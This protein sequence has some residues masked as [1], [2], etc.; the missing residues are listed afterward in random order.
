MRPSGFLRLPEELMRRCLHRV[1]PQNLLALAAASKGCCESASDPQLWRKVFIDQWRFKK[2]SQK[3]PICKHPDP[4]HD[5]KTFCR[6]LHSKEKNLFVCC[7]CEGMS[8][9]SLQNLHGHNRRV[10][11]PIQ[12]MKPSRS[13]KADREE[14]GNPP[15]EASQKI[16]K[17]KKKKDSSDHG[18]K[19]WICG[20]V[21]CGFESLSAAKTGLEEHTREVLFYGFNSH[22]QAP[23][24]KP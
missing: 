15:K 23:S 19:R 6:R 21:D 12:L 3:L 7:N 17:E 9:K 24:L 13:K 4:E 2:G 16:I 1:P 11:K 8:F 10:H 5:W 14:R 22:P 18:L 20:H